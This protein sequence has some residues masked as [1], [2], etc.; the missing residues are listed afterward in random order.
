MIGRGED[1]KKVLAEIRQGLHIIGERFE[2]KEYALME[3]E[4]A[5]ELFKESVK[6]VENLTD[7]TYPGSTAETTGKNP[8]HHRKTNMEKSNH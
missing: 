7:K 6:I 5:T 1:P 8:R 2:A 4:M 3:L